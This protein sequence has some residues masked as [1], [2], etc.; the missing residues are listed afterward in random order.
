V[1]L[2]SGLYALIYVLA[3]ALLFMFAL[4]CSI[5]FIAG[6]QCGASFGYYGC[7]TSTVDTGK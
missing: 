3:G 7:A 1:N 6:G 5:G 4:L 2:R